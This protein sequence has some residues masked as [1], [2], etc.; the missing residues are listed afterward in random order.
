MLNG[1]W[2]ALTSMHTPAR[3]RIP[4]RSLHIA[5]EEGCEFERIVTGKGRCNFAQDLWHF[6]R[7]QS[8]S[9]TSLP[10][11]G[12]CY[13]SF[14]APPRLCARRHESSRRSIEKCMRRQFSRPSSSV[15]GRYT[16][17]RRHMPQPAPGPVSG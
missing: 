15:A 5:G 13:P 3:V 10:T 7:A 16:C 4:A 11:L 8:G 14:N 17:P 1:R 12:T 2:S 9:L 6:T